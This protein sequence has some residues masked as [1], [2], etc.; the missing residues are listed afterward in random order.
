T[1][2]RY[3]G[4]NSLELSGGSGGSNFDIQSIPANSSVTVD[5]AGDQAATFSVAAPS[6]NLDYLPGTLDLI[7]NRGGSEGAPGQ[8]VVTDSK[9]PSATNWAVTS[10][11]LLRHRTGAPAD[12]KIL[13]TGMGTVS[14]QGGTNATFTV[15]QDVE[16]STPVSLT[17]G[18][19]N[20]T[21]IGPSSDN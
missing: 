10:G 3:G 16:S 12:T 15:P 20:S 8:L 5:A 9:A 14:V 19:G 11:L 13:Y 18:G 4:I 17:G 21:L 7:G 1:V 6:G 2:I